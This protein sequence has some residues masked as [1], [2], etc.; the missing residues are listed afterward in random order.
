MIDEG[1][2]KLAYASPSVRR[3]ARDLGVDLIQ[4]SG[5]GRKQRILKEDIYNHVKAVMTAPPAQAAELWNSA[6]HYTYA[7]N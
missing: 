1:G 3:V 2:F 4:V 7:R 5:T 6:W